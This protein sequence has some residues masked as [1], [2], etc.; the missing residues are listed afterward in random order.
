[1]SLKVLNKTINIVNSCK[2]IDQL[3]MAYQY[4]MVAYRK[5]HLDYIQ[6]S[7]IYKQ[8][9]VKIWKTVDNRP[10]P[11]PFAPPTTA[12][13]YGLGKKARIAP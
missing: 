7:H 8:F 2:T 6:V 1:M 5:Q 13:A 9:F 11:K 10:P 4:M 12:K 3:N